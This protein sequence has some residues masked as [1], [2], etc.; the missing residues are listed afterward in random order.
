VGRPRAEPVLPEATLNG[1]KERLPDPAAYFLGHDFEGVLLPGKKGEYYGIPPSKAHALEG[2]DGYAFE[3]DG[4]APLFSLAQGGLAEVWTGGCYPFDEADL[5]AF[6]FGYA[7]LAPHYAEVARRIG[8]TGVADDLAAYLPVHD[9]LQAPLRLDPQATRLLER[10][11]RRGERLARLGCRVGRARVAVLS[12]V[13]EG[14]GACR[15]LGR[16]LWGCPENALYTPLATLQICLRHPAFRYLEGREALH[17]EATEGGRIT[18]LVSRCRSDGSLERHP[19]DRLVLAAGTLG[20]ARILLESL[21]QAGQRDPVLSGLMDNRQVLLPFLHWRSVGQPFP[22]ESYQYHQLALALDAPD[23]ADRVLGLITTLKTCL[24]HP[25][26]QS[27]PLHL[28][29]ALD[30]TRAAH[31]GL[32]ILNVNFRDTRRPGNQVGLVPGATSPRLR[33]RYAPDPEEASWLRPALARVRRAL[34][35]LGCL[36]PPGFAYVRPMGASAHYAGLV[37]LAREGGTGTATPEGRSRD[38]EN[39][40]LADGITFPFLPAKN[41]TFTLMANAVRVA[42]AEFTH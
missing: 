2:P 7:G 28:R 11:R 36:V 31:A 35:A 37:P 3:A 27:V 8:I 16:C 20:S 22:D 19:L 5:R 24:V 34:R 26:A 30:V 25:I 12:T 41:L 42:R 21:R 14:R 17:F 40:W 18:A 23:P 38:F 10:Y 32:G 9:G 39:L 4:F 1:L 15:Y 29:A 13:H 33:I 6:P